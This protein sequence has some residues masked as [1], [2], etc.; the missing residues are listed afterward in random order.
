MSL[1]NEISFLG[2]FLSS[3][4]AATFLPFSSEAILALMQTQ[5]F[6]TKMMLVVATFGNTL[7]GVFTYWIGH[8]GRLDWA[9][10]YLKIKSE[11]VFKLQTKFQRYGHLIAFFC[12]L[13]L[14]GDPLALALG[15]FRSDWKKVFFFM[16][17]GKFL[18][19]FVLIEV[20]HYMK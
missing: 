13:P 11:A 17:I 2:L 18:R 1:I 9:E 12:W 6:D 10:K 3:F 14:I 4:L 5:G 8:L 20:V 19:Y 7:G 15:Y 16:G